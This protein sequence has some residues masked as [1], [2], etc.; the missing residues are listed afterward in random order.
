MD[1]GSGDKSVLFTAP[2]GMLLGMS[3]LA[4]TGKT[5]RV[6]LRGKEKMAGLNMLLK[7]QFI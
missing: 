5:L 6:L 7:K 4:P 2:K 3:C 1:C